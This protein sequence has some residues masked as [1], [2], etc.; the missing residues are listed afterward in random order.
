MTDIAW[1]MQRVADFRPRLLRMALGPVRRY[2]H[3][4]RLRRG[5]VAASLEDSLLSGI[6]SDDA[7]YRSGTAVCR[8]IGSLIF[9]V[10]GKLRWRYRSVLALRFFERMSFSE[11]AQVMGWTRLRACICLFLAR[12]SL[13]RHLSRRGFGKSS[14]LPALTLFGQLTAQP[15]EA[16]S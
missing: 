2:C 8:E 14:L 15:K 16:E 1:K 10:I 11:I 13:M 9:D 6:L 3:S 4:L 12:W 5:A 7:G